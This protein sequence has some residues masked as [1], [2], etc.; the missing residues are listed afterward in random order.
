MPPFCG[1]RV[2]LPD[3]LY[4]PSIPHHHHHPPPAPVP[5][6]PVVVEVGPAC[7]KCCRNRGDK[8]KAVECVSCDAYI[9]DMCHWCENPDHEIRKCLVCADAQCTDCLEEMVPCEGCE[10]RM[11]GDCAAQCQV[12]RKTICGAGERGEDSREVCA[13]QCDGEQCTSDM[14][15]GCAKSCHF[16]TKKMCGVCSTTCGHCDISVCS[17]DA[18]YLLQCQ[19]CSGAFLCLVCALKKLECPKCLSRPSKALLRT[20]K[21]RSE[22]L[23]SLCDGNQTTVPFVL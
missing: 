10:R 8:K 12:C 5:P 4:F 16:C 9:C 14:C 15:Q 1:A 22:A 18:D 19:E 7:L 23:V 13:M 20:A 17:K 21:E 11:C 6:P 3:L 2:A